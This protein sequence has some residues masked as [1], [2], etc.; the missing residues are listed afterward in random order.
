MPRNHNDAVAPSPRCRRRLGFFGRYHRLPGVA[1]P[2]TE[3]RSVPRHRPGWPG[4]R[5]PR[6]WPRQPRDKFQVEKQFLKNG[7]IAHRRSLRYPTLEVQ[8][9][10]NYVVM[11]I[12]RNWTK[13]VRRMIQMM[14]LSRC[15]TSKRTL[16]Y[17]VVAFRLGHLHVP[18]TTRLQHVASVVSRLYS[19]YVQL[20]HF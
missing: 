1:R 17:L 5:S 16:L 19:L 8:G 2:R 14:Y 4:G 18:L 3:H 7:R 11:K 20:Q 12:C 13:K 15:R 9:L 10:K 6:A